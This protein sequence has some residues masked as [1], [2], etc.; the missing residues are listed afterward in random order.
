MDN[1]K[2]AIVLTTMMASASLTLSSCSFMGNNKSSENSDSITIS[3][4]QRD[5]I[6]QSRELFAGLSKEMQDELYKILWEMD[7]IAGKTF[8]LERQREME[9]GVEKKVVDRIKKR[10]A[11][12]KVELENA[13]K[14]AEST[15]QLRSML[16]QLRRSLLDRDDEIER[17]KTKLERKKSKLQRKLDELGQTKNSLEDKIAEL[18]M[19][20]SSLGRAESALSSSKATAWSKAGA[21]LMESR[22]VINVTKKKGLGKKVMEAKI[23]ITEQAI[24]CFEKARATGD[25]SAEDNIRRANAD[26]QRLKNGENI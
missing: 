1:R 18:E 7:D 13:G 16:S 4:A 12:V 21:R 25:P 5:S 26:L 6:I 8:D 3:K 11:A 20:R 14:K 24:R 2:I 23:R 10:I 22:N 19:E 17:L 15:P 9:G